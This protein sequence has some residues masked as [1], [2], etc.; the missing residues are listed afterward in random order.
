MRG[1]YLLALS[2]T[3]WG[4]SDGSE[5][6]PPVN[7]PAPQQ[8]PAPIPVQSPP[9]DTGPPPPTVILDK[10]TLSW[11]FGTWVDGANV[12]MTSSTGED[13]SAR[14]SFGM[15]S[16]HAELL[17]HSHWDLT[18]DHKSILV[19]ARASAPVTILV[20]TARGDTL[21]YWSSLSAEHPWRVAQMPLD[22]TW[23]DLDIPIASLQA[24]GPGEPEPFTPGSPTGIVLFGFILTN[25]G[26][27]DV[28]FEHIEI[29]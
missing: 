29:N 8:T 20:T 2:L 1:R 23:T 28:W 3:L 21:D 11:P 14:F 25:P 26:A 18:R 15:D 19:R 27:I 17:T 16:Q 22:T 13:G 9:V 12:G 5:G 7:Q 4:C 24:E 10:G 6:L